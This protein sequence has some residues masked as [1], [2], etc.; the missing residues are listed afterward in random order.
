[1]K[2]FTSAKVL[3]LAL[4]LAVGLLGAAPACAQTVTIGDANTTEGSG[5]TKTLSFTVNATNTGMAQTPAFTLRADTELVAGEAETADV[6]GGNDF[7]PLINQILSFPALASGQS[8]QQV[9]SVTLNGD[10]LFEDDEVFTVDLD[11]ETG[12]PTLTDEAATGTIGNDDAV[13]SVSIN[14]VTVC[15]DDGTAVFSLTLSNPTELTGQVNFSTQNGSAFAGQDYTAA[16]GTVT[17]TPFELT[18][19]VS[20]P[21][22]DDGLLE[23][24]ETFGLQLSLPAGSNLQFTGSSTGIATL[25]DNDGVNIVTVE[26]ITG[27]LSGVVGEQQCYLITTLNGCGERVA[28]QTVTVVVSGTTGNAD[29]VTV[30]TNAAGEAT[31]CFTPFFPGD[32]TLEITSGLGSSVFAGFVDVPGGSTRGALASGS[33]VVGGFG[34]LDALNGSAPAKF[35]FNA[36]VARNGRPKG[37]LTFVQPGT[38]IFTDTGRRAGLNFRSLRFT[39]VQT[40]EPSTGG[41]RLVIFGVGRFDRIP[42]VFAFRAD[43]LDLGTPGVPGD[44][45]ELR[46]LFPEGVLNL[47]PEPGTDSVATAGGALRF[48]DSPALRR[49]S[50]V[51][52]RLGF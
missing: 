44:R 37:S 8:S 49:N 15:E 52:I 20:I 21:I 48:V 5:G 43:A 19:T 40:F 29:V 3:S 47:T 38:R 45:F 36:S 32:F 9:V 51:K 7:E 10:T 1:M 4:G 2:R 30:T 24:N 17:F 13:P 12:T 14:N 34:T 33:G 22:L 25:G 11:A 35:N 41:R 46:V 28:N 23:P 16:S 50:D 6:P 27:D 31:F 18:E 26:D 39:S 42:G